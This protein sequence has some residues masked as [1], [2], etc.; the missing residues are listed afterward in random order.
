MIETK[1]PKGMT[2]EKKLESA[3]LF[4]KAQ[5]KNEKD[6]MANLANI[7]AI[8]NMYMDDINWVGFYLMKEGTL[9]LGPF[10]GKPACNRI[11]VGEGVCGTAVQEGKTQRVDDVLSLDNHI[12]CDSASRSELVVPIYKE[13][14]V[15]GVLDIDSPSLARFSDLEQTYMEKL[16]NLLESSL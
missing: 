8:I 4:T 14:V 9:I 12:A 7:S 13:G 6:T 5:L 2:A 11:A 3:L 10:Q 16:V 15:F 1:D